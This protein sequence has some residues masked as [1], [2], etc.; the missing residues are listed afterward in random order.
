MLG[1]SLADGTTEPPVPDRLGD[2]AILR[3]IAHGGMGEIYEAVQVAA[4]MREPASRA[5]V[6]SERA[7]ASD[8]VAHAVKEI[9]P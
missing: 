5:P 6:A 7:A 8:S 9:V 4:G 2:F 3:R 1:G